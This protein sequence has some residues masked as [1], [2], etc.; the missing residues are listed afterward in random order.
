MVMR[1]NKIIFFMAV[2]G[3]FV[4]FGVMTVSAYDYNTDTMYNDGQT[5]NFYKALKGKT[6]A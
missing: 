1:L 3:F 2:I 5:V 6:V 4:G